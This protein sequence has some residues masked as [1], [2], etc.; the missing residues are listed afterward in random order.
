[1]F[2]KDKCVL[3]ISQFKPGTVDKNRLFY[4][5]PVGIEPTPLSCRCNVL[6]T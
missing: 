5:P 1:M 2:L 6:I 3:H 4:G